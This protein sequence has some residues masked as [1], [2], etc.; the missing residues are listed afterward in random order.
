[1]NNPSNPNDDKDPGQD[2]EASAP[3]AE[4]ERPPE[5]EE[6]TPD[7]EPETAE[8][9]A[10]DPEPEATASDDAQTDQPDHHADHDTD[11]HEDDARSGGGFAATALKYLL[12]VLAIFG[13]SLWLVPKAAPHLP[14]SIAKHIIPQQTVLDERLAAIEAKAESAAADGVVTE[15]RQQ[16]A[17]LTQRLESTEAALAT[18]QEEVAAARTAAEASAGA[19][20]ASGIAESVVVEAQEAASDAARAAEVATAAATEAGKVASAATRDVA[21]LSRQMTSYE[22]R[23]AT[24]RSEVEAVGENLSAVAA[25]GGDASS[26]EITAAFA[27]LKAKVDTLAEAQPDTSVFMPR[28]E[29]NTFATHDDLRSA[30]TALRADMDAAI[31]SLP[32]GGALATTTALGDVQSAMDSKLGE[33]GSQISDLS[34]QATAAAETAELARAASEEAVSTVEG[35]IQNASLKAAAAALSSQMANGA[36]FARSLD[37]IVALT[38]APAPEALLA[39]APGGAKTLDALTR[40]FIAQA[41]EAIKADLRAQSD[42]SALGQAAARV[43]SLFAG[44]PKDA[45]EGDDAAAIV[46]RI[47]AELRGANLAAAVG[48]AEGLSDAAKTVLDGWLS[49]ARARMAA[50]E[51]AAALVED[52]LGSQ[53]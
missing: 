22:A 50:D 51:A 3:E 15:L 5:A 16:V 24:L 44:R 31:A 41:P 9:D 45:V 40:A 37:E 12:I 35:A 23:L 21:S 10:P 8:P 30:R 19:A 18:A 28:D 7:A 38:G 52:I 29:M 11:H 6:A 46:S 4:G 26:A 39:V 25:Q 48:E 49:D 14:T 34:A 42:G 47:E 13:L 17:D 33:V 53:G 36:P 20:S 27:A 43:E 1:M 32:D 2:T